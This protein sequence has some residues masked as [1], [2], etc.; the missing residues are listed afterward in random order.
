MIAK[1]VQQSEF[2]AFPTR[3]AMFAITLLGLL[4]CRIAVA[5]PLLICGIG[6]RESPQRLRA[7]ALQNEFL[8]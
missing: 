8:I 4:H 6:A 3:S 1:P 2:A 5:A 7:C